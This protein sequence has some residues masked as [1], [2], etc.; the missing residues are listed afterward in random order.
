MV[1]TIKKGWRYLTPQFCG[2][3]LLNA[4]VEATIA[5]INALLQHYGAPT[6]LG[7][8]LQ[9]SIEALQLKLG[10]PDNPFKYPFDVWGDLATDSWVKSLW[11]RI[12]NYDI[13][14]KLDYPSIAS[15][16]NTTDAS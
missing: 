14:L 12:D 16:G 7:V 5:S 8:T 4:G 3:G 1:R 9:A 11:E 6:N 2:I 15:P 10:V 13:A